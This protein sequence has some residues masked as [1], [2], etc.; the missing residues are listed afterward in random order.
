MDKLWQ[1]VRY[2]LR[3]LAKQPGFA[4]VALF[5]LALGIGANTAIFSV[6]NAVLLRFLPVPNPQQVFYLHTGD[7]AGSQSGYGDTSLPEPVFEN[8]RKQTDVFSDLM[9]YVPLSFSKVA[10]RYGS[11]PQEAEADMVSGNFFSGLGVQAIAGRGFTMDDESNHTLNAVISYS[12]WTARL[13][14]GRAH[15]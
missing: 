7:I 3:M 2:A 11:V 10:V 1:D 8:L 4:M 12:Y 6:M 9:A 14:I 5:T 15:V 13:E